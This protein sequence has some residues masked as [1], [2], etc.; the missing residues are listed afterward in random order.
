[1]EREPVVSDRKPVGRRCGR[2]VFQYI[3]EWEAARMRLLGAT[4]RAE[5]RRLLSTL[6]DTYNRHNRPDD[7]ELE[8]LGR[9]L[10]E[11]LDRVR[12]PL[13]K[14]LIAGV[15]VLVRT[16]REDAEIQIVAAYYG[17]G[18]P[19]NTTVPDEAVPE[20]KPVVRG[21]WADH[22]APLAMAARDTS[23]PVLQ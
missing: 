20:S 14:P 19:R 3:D 16:A 17:E 10:D 9:A 21:P 2:W 8:G 6:R 11:A 23:G 15:A 13:A 1:M 5:M 12:A 7:I 22:S 18:D 4:G